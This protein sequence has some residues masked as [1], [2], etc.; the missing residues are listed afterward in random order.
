MAAMA[1]KLAA[2]E[3]VHCLPPFSHALG[4]VTLG[5]T[6]GMMETRLSSMFS[7]NRVS[8]AMLHAPPHSHARDRAHR[9]HPEPSLVLCSSAR[10]LGWSIYPHLSVP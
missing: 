8:T 4:Q 2:A 5:L 10:S 6:S 1:L 3:L 7:Q 9:C